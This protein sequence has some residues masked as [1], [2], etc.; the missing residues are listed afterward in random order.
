M[1]RYLYVGNIKKTQLIELE[2]DANSGGYI[3][4]RK[5]NLK[6]LPKGLKEILFKNGLFEHI[7]A[8]YRKY[9]NL[10]TLHRLVLC[11]YE[12]I[13]NLE[14][15]HILKDVIFNSIINLIPISK[16]NHI[17]IG[18]QFEEQGIAESEKVQLRLRNKI[19]KPKKNTL[20]NDDDLILEILNM[21]GQIDEN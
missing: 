13:A 2:Q 21:K 17:K 8:A 4:F 11:C 15:H 16:E 9:D 6:T 18:K 12:K 5:S 7:E 10:F 14:V 19:F 1:K 3:V 20:A